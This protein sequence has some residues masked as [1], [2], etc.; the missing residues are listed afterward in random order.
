LDAEHF[1]PGVLSPEGDS[2]LLSVVLRTS[3]ASLSTDE[4]ICEGGY[5]IMK[6]KSAWVLGL[7]LVLV[8]MFLVGCGSVAEPC[9]E[10]PTAVPCPECPDCPA[11]DCPELAPAAVDCSECPEPDAACPF[12]GEWAASPHADAKARAFSRWNEDEPPVVPA[13]CAKC[14][15]DG[16]FRE[17]LGADGTETR[18]VENDQPT[19]TVVSCAACH[20]EAAMSW[21]TVVFPSGA[22]IAGLGPEARCIECHH[23]RDSGVSVD[24]SIA[25]AGLED[26]DTVSDQLAFTNIHYF[27]AAATMYGTQ[28]QGGYEYEGKS[29]DAKSDHVADLDTCVA[30]HNTHTL[31]PKLEV[32]AECHGDVTSEED[33]RDIRAQ[34]SLVD[35]DGD[36]NTEE[37]IYYELDGLREM[38]YEAI[39]AYAREVSDQPIAYDPDS[40]PYFFVDTNA[41]GALDGDEAGQD[42][43]FS[44]WT[45]R[46]ARAAYNYQTSV[47]DPGAYAHGG[48]YIIQ[49]LYDSIEDLNEA[50]SSPI[51]LSEARRI[52]HRHFAGSEPAFRNWDEEGSVPRY[53]AKCHTAV[54]LPFFLAEGVHISQRPTNGLT[55]TTCHS[56]LT[57]FAIHEVPSVTFPRGAVI[58]SGNLSSNLCLNCHQGLSSIA[59]VNA[60]IVGLD[61]DTVSE[62]LEFINIHN[63]VA[64]A[65]LYGTEVQGAYEYAE[66]QYAGRLTHV[67]SFNTCTQC[68]DHHRQEVE[69][70]ECSACHEGVAGPEDLVDI[71]M[72]S[73]DYDGDG[74]TSEGIAGEIATIRDA[75]YAGI[76]VYAAGVAGAPI[77]YE[78]ATSP[79]FFADGN[80]NGQ[81]EPE[82][83]TASNG[84]AAWTPRLLRAAYN[85][86]YSVRDP[87]AFAHNA[88]YVLQVL[89]DTLEDVGGDVSGLVRP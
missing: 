6:W 35:Y 79:F 39:Q 5:K 25:E 57:T 9:P 32:C 66:K 72:D 44:A 46:L 75:L 15:S 7:G 58:D 27:A 78:S 29:Y 43:G 68:H 14:H 56:D 10:C 8:G 17:F 52:D 62:D 51:N 21:D 37:G 69:V 3:Q 28:A 2:W 81:L 63:L 12:Q 65:T 20:N 87:G 83:A 26:D 76:Q 23:G 38:L 61:L 42:N 22:V 70:V 30:C 11:V 74:D 34:G 80:G 54:G 82:E 16:G 36:G 55:C 45:G 49:L 71:R 47:K 85:Y 4:A 18:V 1:A 41:S 53:C 33:L 86:H 84:Y 64:G 50:L 48:K 13:D 89:H 59:T 77:V 73:T 31:A 40:Y 88:E 67:E 60:A 19:G 24:A